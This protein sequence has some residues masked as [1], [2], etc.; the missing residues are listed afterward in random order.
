MRNSENKSGRAN[1]VNLNRVSP[2]VRT[3]RYNPGGQ[4]GSLCLQGLDLSFAAALSDDIQRVLD[5]CFE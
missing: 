3:T 4:L 2:A 1:S 5:L